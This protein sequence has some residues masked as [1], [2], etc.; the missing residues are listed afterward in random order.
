M[1]GEWSV[2]SR[3]RFV[4]RL[5][6]DLTWSDA[7]LAAKRCGKGALR[8]I[9]YPR[10]NLAYCER[11][12]EQQLTALMQAS[13]SNECLRREPSFADKAC[14]ES[15]HRKAHRPCKILYLEWM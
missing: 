4:E 6:S 1:R 10:C 15:L 9:T 2:A 7:E 13:T 5:A 3:L 11:G 12:A 8:G 14:V